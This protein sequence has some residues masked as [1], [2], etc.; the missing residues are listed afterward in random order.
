M[1]HKNRLWS[2]GPVQT[3]E[4]LAQK[5]SDGRTWTLCTGFFVEGHDNYLFLNDS[6]S[7]DGAGE[8]AVVKAKVGDTEGTQIES[9]TFGWCGIPKALEYI[10]CIL[11]GL[12][13]SGAHQRK[14]VPFEGHVS[15]A[16]SVGDL[17]SLLA[18]GD[19]VATTGIP[20]TLRTVP[21]QGHRCGLC[22]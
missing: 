1:F 19:P 15:V 16:T 12:F 20:V 5:L 8:W 2:I 4:E 7:E 17:K 18:D 6:L 14:P 13:E 22:A 3:P 9:I 21:C 10:R 11:A